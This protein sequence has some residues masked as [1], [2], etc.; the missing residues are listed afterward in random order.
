M[1]SIENRNHRRTSARPYRDIFADKFFFYSERLKHCCG[2]NLIAV[3]IHVQII[4]SQNR[5][6]LGLVA[7][8]YAAKIGI[9]IRQQI[10]APRR[11]FTQKLR[12]ALKLDIVGVRRISHYFAAERRSH[13]QHFD[14]GLVGL[15]KNADH[16]F[17]E[18]LKFVAFFSPT[19]I[20]NAS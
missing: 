12:V 20:V 16:V 15:V 7:I 14:S 9:D 4:D 8:E 19:N 5:T 6:A 3:T 13:D 10:S 2:N 11:F 17:F 18:R 1:P